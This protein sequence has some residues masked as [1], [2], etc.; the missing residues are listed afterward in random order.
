MS[1]DDSDDDGSL[2]NEVDALTQ[3]SN[4]M[5][6]PRNSVLPKER[7]QS[8]AVSVDKKPVPK[9]R[10]ASIREA[11]LDD[12]PEAML[13]LI[14]RASGVP[15][16]I[17]STQKSQKGGL[18]KLVLTQ[19]P[20]SSKKSEI[21]DLMSEIASLTQQI[22]GIKAE[23][24]QHLD[25]AKSQNMD[26]DETVVSLLAQILAKKD[27]LQETLNTKRDELKTMKESLPKPAGLSHDELINYSDI[28]DSQKNPHVLDKICKPYWLLVS[29]LRVSHT[30]LSKL[31]SKTQADSVAVEAVG[32]GAA[33][34]AVDGSIA[35]EAVHDADGKTSKKKVVPK[36]AIVSVYGEFDQVPT[37]SPPLTR[38][39]VILRS[40]V[41]SLFQ[42][43]DILNGAVRG[44]TK[45]FA[46]FPEVNEKVQDQ[47]KRKI[48][49]QFTK[50]MGCDNQFPNEDD[51]RRALLH[52]VA[53]L[54]HYKNATRYA[55]LTLNDA[56][57]KK[58]FHEVF[59]DAEPVFKKQFT[60]IRA[61][62]D[63]FKSECRFARA[64]GGG[65]TERNIENILCSFHQSMQGV[66]ESG[67]PLIGNKSVRTAEQYKLYHEIAEHS[68][69]KESGITTAKFLEL[70]RVICINEGERGTKTFTV[71]PL[72]AN[73]E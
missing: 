1:Q 53:A 69:V 52:I 28:M 29:N 49:V 32:T 62:E 63:L 10:H 44:Y 2:F 16:P 70:N 60:F 15:K 38:S 13:N 21:E 51:L 11:V 36:F 14:L 58:H 72:P 71:L 41:D 3:S 8:E 12:C 43:L 7:N 54:E 26:K 42:I 23:H 48:F 59:V 18:T 27:P 67:L 66:P 35:A 33:V 4:S 55:G 30:G 39:D 20:E 34:H 47:L 64:A 5:T 65:P 31:K 68:A 56:L 9:S 50:A 22:A 37:K 57:S 73:D 45:I 40:D 17:P 24:K 19:V 25:R 61:K 6:N 46:V